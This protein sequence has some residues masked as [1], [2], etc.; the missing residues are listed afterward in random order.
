M[1]THTAM[2]TECSI[3]SSNESSS[4]SEP[5]EPKLYAG[6][7]ITEEMG[8]ILL[9]SLATRHKLTNAAFSDVLRVVRLHLHAGCIT[10]ASYASLYKLLKFVANTQESESAKIDHHLCGRCGRYLQEGQCRSTECALL[11]SEHR[12]N[13][14]FLE[15][16]IE[17]QIKTFFRSK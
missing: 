14:T 8:L 17:D 15:L 7:L 2:E 16:P 3:D 10:P 6:A 12:D 1:S 9:L 5:P 13:S 11:D 4:E